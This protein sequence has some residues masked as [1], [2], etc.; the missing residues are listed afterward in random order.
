MDRIVA[1]A[2]GAC[3]LLTV[4]VCGSLNVPDRYII[5]IGAAYGVPFLLYIWTRQGGMKAPFM[6]LWPMLWAIHAALALAGVP[7]FS[8]EPNAVTSLVPVVGYGVIAAVASHIY[9]RIT[10]RRLRA[11]ARTGQSPE[12]GVGS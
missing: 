12:T 9:S 2:F 7:P 10:L 5:P 4:I 11:M 3:V 8:D 1:F 6:L